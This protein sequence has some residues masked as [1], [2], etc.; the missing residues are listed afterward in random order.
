MGVYLLNAEGTEI[1]H[2]FDTSNS[3]LPSDK[4]YSVC[5]HQATGA[6]LIV[7]PSGIVEYRED[8]TPAALSY[9]NVYAFPNPVQSSFTGFVTIK[10]LM[11][12][13]N[14]LITDIDGNI[15]ARL[16]SR[17]GTA[18]WDGCD[19][20]GNRLETGIYKVFASQGT[21]STSGTPVTR[22]AIVK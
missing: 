16:T 20:N 10:N 11:E 3:M 15:V 14:V 19:S 8:I 4:I 12:N 7:T 18:L 9:N 21:P 22:I 2:H 6:V 1:T 5:C 17:G 13:S